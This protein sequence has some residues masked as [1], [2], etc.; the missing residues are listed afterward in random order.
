MCS[1]QK[2][3][4]EI[5]SQLDISQNNSIMSSIIKMEKEATKMFLYF[6]LS[7]FVLSF[8]GVVVYQNIF[9]NSE[10]FVLNKAKKRFNNNE[11]DWEKLFNICFEINNNNES[12]ELILNYHVNQNRIYSNYN[13]AKNNK[14]EFIEDWKKECPSLYFL[15]KNLDISYAYINNNSFSFVLQGI[16]GKSCLIVYL[17]SSKDVNDLPKNRKWEHRIRDC[18]YIVQM[19]I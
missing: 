6:I 3:K 12:K 15:M 2:T 19:K 9:G 17:T 11:S 16:P 7:F 10:S 13:N 4:V 1:S 8:I 14:G 18:V 5:I